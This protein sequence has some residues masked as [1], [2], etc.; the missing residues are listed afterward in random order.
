MEKRLRRYLPGGKFKDVRPDRSRAMR[1]VKGHGTKTTERRLR[2]ALVRAGIRHW[3][4]QPKGLPG[5]PDI[6]FP[7]KQLVIFVDGCFWHGCPKCG[8]LPRTNRAFWKAKI[9]GNKER[10]RICA[11]KL[12]NEGFKVLHFWEHELVNNLSQCIQDVRE[13]LLASR[14]SR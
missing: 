5:S 13:L 6:L 1:A 11:R 12:R 3:K 8:H 14:S 9:L 10:D 7:G 4:L 2:G